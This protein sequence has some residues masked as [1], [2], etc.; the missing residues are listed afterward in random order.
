MLAKTNR[1]HTD[2]EIKDLIKTGRVFFLPQF[3]I[4]FKFNK[5][6]NTKFAFVVSTKVD[7]RAVVRHKLARRLREVARVL[8][9]QIKGGYSI[10]IIAK[11]SAL[12]LELSQLKQQLIFAF[13]KIK[14]YNVS[15]YDRKTK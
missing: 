12:G 3:T 15:S 9:P 11:K 14:L 5:T 8:L 6:A 4:K 2:K 7:K 10:I 1:L 13:T